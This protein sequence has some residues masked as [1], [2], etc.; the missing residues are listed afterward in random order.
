MTGV[1]V[2]GTSVAGAAVAGASVV[3][4]AAVAGSGV[5]L[6]AVRAAETTRALPA[7]AREAMTMP[8]TLAKAATGR[9]TRVKTLWRRPCWAAAKTSGTMRAARPTGATGA[10]V[11]LRAEISVC[12]AAA[13]AAHEGQPAR[14]A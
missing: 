7:A 5:R 1:A 10:G 6:P 12:R 2:A 4:G 13:S 9:N 14:C 3:I 8:K 11:A